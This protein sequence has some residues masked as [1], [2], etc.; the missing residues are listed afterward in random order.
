MTPTATISK[1]DAYYRP[2][3]NPSRSCATCAMFL[4]AERRCT[5]VRG[6]IKP[7][8]TCDYWERRTRIAK[9][10]ATLPVTNLHGVGLHH[11]RVIVLDADGRLLLLL[12]SDRPVWETINGTIGDDDAPSRDETPTDAAGRELEEET[13][14]GGASLTW[15]KLYERVW[16]V[17]LPVAAPDPILS[18]EHTA[19]R[20]FP[21][22]AAEAWL[23]R[24]RLYGRVID[25]AH[26]IDASYGPPPCR[27]SE[28]A[29]TAY[30]EGGHAVVGIHWNVP[31]RKVTIVPREGDRGHIELDG[32]GGDPVGD[33]IAT[34]AGP[35]ASA[36][37]AARLGGRSDRA[38]AA[39]L[40]EGL[41]PPGAA[42]DLLNVAGE[43]AREI[44]N[45]PETWRQVEA[46]AEALLERRTLTGEEVKQIMAEALDGNAA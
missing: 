26:S 22:A 7:E 9:S 25:A 1:V 37:I 20:W 30:H 32:D 8:D 23:A 4:A 46:V 10:P 13:G 43:A 3:T 44:V 24:E 36:R 17:R 38:V 27:F 14:Y 41:A 34:L 29:A 39:Q 15:E 28:D 12:R 45:D 18:D 19:F 2:A 5:L 42:D 11:V 21:P 31:V 40:A 33:L 6:K 16:V 35:A